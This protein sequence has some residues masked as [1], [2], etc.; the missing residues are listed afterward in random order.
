[1]LASPLQAPGAIPPRPR[2]QGRPSIDAPSAA[3]QA[4]AAPAQPQPALPPPPRA[5]PLP[6]SNNALPFARLAL[7]SGASL[8]AAHLRKLGQL[9]PP[10]LPLLGAAAPGAA[11]GRAAEVLQVS[12][13]AG[14]Q[15]GGCWWLGGWDGL[16]D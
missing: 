11:W 6:L 7:P 4:S 8:L 1:M 16:V 2:A 12:D 13:A 5:A 14:L 3:A 9:V 10:Q 15:V